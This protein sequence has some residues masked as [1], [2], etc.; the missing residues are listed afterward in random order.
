MNIL[1]PYSSEFT[2]LRLCSSHGLVHE[3]LVNPGSGAALGMTISAHRRATCE[4]H[5]NV[6]SKPKIYS[7]RKLCHM[8]PMTVNGLTQKSILQVFYAL[9]VVSAMLLVKRSWLC[10]KI[11]RVKECFCICYLLPCKETF[12][13]QNL[14][15]FIDL[16]LS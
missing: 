9:K 13:H 15:H 10:S 6:D 1:Q 7:T 2:F 11:A 16:L 4:A 3:E 12:S 5:G 8:E 14:T